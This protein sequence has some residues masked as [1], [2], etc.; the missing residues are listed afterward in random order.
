MSEDNKYGIEDLIS[1]AVLQ[2]PM[3]FQSAFNNIVIDRIRDAVENKKIEV[4]Q[5]LYNY[6]PDEANDSE[7][8]DNSEEEK[9]GEVA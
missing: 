3:E 7:E 5:Q 8:L 1:N 9:N 4:A 6:N 2:K